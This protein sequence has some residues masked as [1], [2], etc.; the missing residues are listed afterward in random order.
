MALDV[1]CSAELHRGACLERPM[2]RLGI[3][4]LTRRCRSLRRQPR[5]LT[6]SDRRHAR[7]G[8]VTR[9]ARLVRSHTRA[10][11]IQDASQLRTLHASPI[12]CDE[13]PIPWLD[14]PHGPAGFCTHNP[15]TA[16][17]RPCDISLGLDDA[18]GD[19]IV[20]RERESLAGTAAVRSTPMLSDLPPAAGTPPTI[21]SEHERRLCAAFTWTPVCT[22]AMP[23]YMGACREPHWG[24]GA[25]QLA[26]WHQ[27]HARRVRRV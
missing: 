25:I 22:A 8:W 6:S 15:S 21:Y 11:L 13:T 2:S 24:Q 10:R 23:A 7:I 27:A 18:T 16:T 1:R 9:R 12:F 3:C 19:L 5:L 20:R 4:P 26:F 17:P 14:P